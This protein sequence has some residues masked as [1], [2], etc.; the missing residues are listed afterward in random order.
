[1]HAT[2]RSADFVFAP[3]ADVRL[4]PFSGSA[5]R[6]AFGH[7]FKRL[8]C[9]LRLRPCSGC[10]L[11]EV[12][13]HPRFF[14]AEPESDAPRPYVLAPQR[15]PAGGLVRAGEPFRL[16]LTLLPGAEPATPYVVRALLE[17]AEAGLTAARVPF[18]CLAVRPAYPEGKGAAGDPLAPVTLAP[19]PAPA[20]LRL[21]FVTPL[22]L[23]LEGDLVTGRTL[24]PAM[25]VAAALR[26]ARLAGLALPAEAARAA[27]AEARALAWQETRLGWLETVRVSSRQQAAMRLGGIVGEAVLALGAAPHVW[28]ALWLGSLLHLGKGTAMGFGGLALDAA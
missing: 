4:Q 11:G 12:C 22:R 17:A 14:G 26:R 15:S 21:G 28:P 25:L 24:T 5:W 2:L 9:S 20:R 10:P 16:R 13:L 8:V 6:G 23:R 19:P 1:M 3:R 18:A 7:A 27:L